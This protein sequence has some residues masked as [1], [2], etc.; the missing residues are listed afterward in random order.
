MKEQVFAR[1]EGGQAQGRVGEQVPYPLPTEAEVRRSQERQR[2]IANGGAEERVEG[3][4]ELKTSPME[5]IK[6]LGSMLAGN[7]KGLR[8]L[9]PRGK[10]IGKGL[11]LAYAFGLTAEVGAAW[12]AKNIYQANLEDNLRSGKQ[13]ERIKLGEIT[14][15]QAIDELM[16]RGTKLGFKAEDMRREGKKDMEIFAADALNNLGLKWA[17]MSVRRGETPKV[18]AN[19]IADFGNQVDKQMAVK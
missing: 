17:E 1:R 15:D 8:I 14:R 19:D 11:L 7:I 6:N 16:A 2:Q 5:R 10:K 3:K 18:V 9:G 4:R 13:A 12:Q